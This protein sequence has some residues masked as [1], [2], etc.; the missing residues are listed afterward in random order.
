[1]EGQAVVGDLVVEGADEGR[2]PHH[3]VGGIRDEHGVARKSAFKAP[4]A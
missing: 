3:V 2:E 1:M 4:S